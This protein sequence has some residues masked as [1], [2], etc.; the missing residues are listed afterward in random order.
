M[1]EGRVAAQTVEQVPPREPKT[2]GAIGS[3]KTFAAPSAGRGGGAIEAGVS[4]PG[5]SHLDLARR[6]PARTASA[7]GL[8]QLAGARANCR[9][10]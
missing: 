2:W 8:V 1:N 10:V 7:Y 5:L 4:R 3:P 9:P 6:G